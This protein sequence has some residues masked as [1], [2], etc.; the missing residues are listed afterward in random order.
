[1]GLTAAAGAV[2]ARLEDE[3]PDV[4]IAAVAALLAL[5]PSARPALEA[6]AAREECA[7]ARRRMELALRR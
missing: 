6:V 3:D 7:W 2:E 1:M 5:R 4:R